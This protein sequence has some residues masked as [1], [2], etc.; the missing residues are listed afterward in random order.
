MALRGILP[1]TQ[2]HPG[3]G[4][5]ENF[6]FLASAH[7][8]ARDPSKIC[9]PHARLADDELTPVGETDTFVYWTCA[10][11]GYSELRYVPLNSDVA[12]A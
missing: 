4:N 1:I 12:S 5:C 6:A 2:L 8:D 10:E 7:P 11:C 9:T 3:R